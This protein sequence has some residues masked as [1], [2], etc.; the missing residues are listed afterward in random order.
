MIG[1]RYVS[2]RAKLMLNVTIILPVY[3]E[4]ALFPFLPTT[5]LKWRKNWEENHPGRKIFLL[6]INDGSTDNT[7]QHC[8]NWAQQSSAMTFINLG[9]NF[10]HQAALSAGLDCCDGNHI[11]CIMDADLQDPLQATEELI[12]KIDEGHDVAYGV[13]SI[14]DGE[15]W[16]KK[17]TAMVFYWLMK[18]ANPWLPRD[19]GDFCAL[20]PK[21][22][23]TLRKLRETH[24]FMRGMRAWI[25]LKQIPVTYHRVARLQGETHYGL[26]K[27]LKFAWDAI[28]SFSPW[29]L[30]LISLTGITIAGI[31]AAYGLY[32][33]TQKFLIGNTVQ[34]W[35]SLIIILCIIGGTQLIALGLIGEY[36]ARIYEESKGRPLY[37]VESIVNSESN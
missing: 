1:A 36:I 22:V 35:T 10:G 2:W 11:V 31:G 9:R 5:I 37:T 33:I 26:L 24:R 18:Q 30:R 32:A 25:G 6:V 20:S 28:L 13:R 27:M 7:W 29:P 19:S 16:F 8:L 34:G 14:R 15:T 21:A 3:N 12:Q 4:E 23:T 17:K